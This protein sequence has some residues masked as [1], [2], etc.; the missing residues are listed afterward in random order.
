MT[1]G[2]VSK[3]TFK[4]YRAA[5]APGLVE[6]GC[7]SIEPMTELQQA[8]IKK[9]VGAGY[10]EGDEIKILTDLPGFSLAY[11]WLKNEYPLSRHSHDSDCMYYVIAGSLQL[12][13][14]TLGPRDSFF[15][16]A[17]VPYTY[18]P[19]PDGVEVLEIR[20]NPDFNF[21]NLSGNQSFWDRAA[22]TCSRNLEGWKTAVRP[23]EK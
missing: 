4:I 19:G 10:L 9:A 11:A 16:P 21:L 3:A 7:M 22:E 2:K 13:T 5:A 23:S 12:G 6:S 17:N 20:H 8:G 18:C 1:D 15:V 14:E